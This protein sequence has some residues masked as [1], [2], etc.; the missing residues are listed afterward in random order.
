MVWCEWCG[1]E[2]ESGFRSQFHPIDANWL[3][4]TTHLPPSSSHLNSLHSRNFETLD[5]LSSSSATPVSFCLRRRSKKEGLS[6]GNRILCMY[7]IIPNAMYYTH[8]IFRIVQIIF[9]IRKTKR[10]EEA[11]TGKGWLSISRVIHHLLPTPVACISFYIWRTTTGWQNLLLSTPFRHL[12]L[13]T[14][15]PPCTRRLHNSHKCERWARE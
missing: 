3:F 7:I 9:S 5:F 8:E 13:P 10:E 1:N 12:L 4:L 14:F 2:M 15:T 11:Q 6:V